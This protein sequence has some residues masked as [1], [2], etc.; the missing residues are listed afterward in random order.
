MKELINQRSTRK[1][2]RIFKRIIPSRIILQVIMIM[3]LAGCLTPVDR[4]SDY[5]GGQVVISGQISPLEETNVIRVGRTS[6]KERL[7]EPVSGAMVTLFDDLGNEALYLEDQEF[8]GKYILQT[9]EGVPGRTYYIRIVIPGGEIYESL[10][11]RMPLAIGND[12]IHHTIVPDQYTD[13]DGVVDERYFVKLYTSHT[14]APSLDPVFIKWHVDEVFSLTPTDFPD[15]FGSVPPPCYISQQVD[16]QKIVLFNGDEVHAT[17]IPDLLLASR[18]TGPSF[19]ER[20]YFTTYQSSL[21]REA[22]EYWREVNIVA[23]QV[24]SIFDPPPGR[25][26]GNIFNVNDPS[27]EV[28]GYFQAVNQTFHRF[29]LLPKDMPFKMTVYCEYGSD[30]AYYDY[31]SECLN[32]LSATNSSYNRP[33]WF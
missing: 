10:P 12:Q 6:N 1:E 32:C 21:T 28:H 31:P 23:N 7:P 16:P 5:I 25:V 11:E 3:I 15:P 19:K 30:R 26:K 22:Y 18:L 29:Y 20:H 8:A 9:F 27:E 17:Y 33:P 14:V 2:K 13:Q 24:G 4:F